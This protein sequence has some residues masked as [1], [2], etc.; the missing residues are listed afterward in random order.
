[1][2]R[3]LVVVDVQRDFCEGGSLA[4]AG[5]A[6]VAERVADLVRDHDGAYDAIVATADWHTDPGTHWSA[7]PDFVDSW[8]VHCAAGT[9]GAEFHE[10]F[11][12]VADRLDAVFRKGQQAAAYSGLE[13]VDEAG[14]GLA[15]WLRAHGVTAVDCVGI[16][17]D[18]CVRAT[19]LDAAREGFATRV[20]LDLTAGVAPDS[21]ARA[22]DELRQA[23]V[24]LVG[25]APTAPP[26]DHPR[27]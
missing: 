6:Q 11:A 24:E 12:P 9:P 27:D 5:G 2:T 25:E 14:Q 16:A 4:V 3:A 15:D 23:G 1:M 22:L 18:H 19:A 10:S 21:T 8:P 7:E 17:T 26:H 13:G 20:L